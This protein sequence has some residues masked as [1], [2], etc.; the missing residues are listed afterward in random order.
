ML[1]VM[2][3][4]MQNQAWEAMEQWRNTIRRMASPHP[5]YEE[6]SLGQSDAIFANVP[7][8]LVN[9]VFVDHELD[10]AAFREIEQFTAARAVPWML[11]APDDV[12]P[13]GMAVAFEITYMRTDVLL[14]PVRQAPDIEF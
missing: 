4:A 14:P 11:V 8:P 10:G 13:E 3:A 7:F 2:Q 6:T 9:T 1:S 12:V 5:G